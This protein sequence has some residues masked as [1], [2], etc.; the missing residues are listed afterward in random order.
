MKI[1]LTR[2]HKA[3]MLQA[4]SDG[5]I[6]EMD[7]NNIKGIETLIPDKPMS[8]V[9]YGWLLKKLKCQDGGE[10]ENEDDDNDN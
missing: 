5:F 8:R 6:Y 2:E 3:V 7:L 10:N 9:D 1:I 4:L